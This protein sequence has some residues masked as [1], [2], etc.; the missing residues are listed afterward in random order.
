[1]HYAILGKRSATVAA[2]VPTRPDTPAP[3]GLSQ[4]PEAGSFLISPDLK[5]YL[6]ELEA[7]YGESIGEIPTTLL[8]STTSRI[9]LYRPHPSSPG[10]WENVLVSPGHGTFDPGFFNNDRYTKTQSNIF[11]AAVLIL[12]ASILLYTCIRVI[13][14]RNKRALVTLEIIGMPPSSIQH[15]LFRRLYSAALAAI[16]ASAFTLASLFVTD[17]SLPGTGFEIRSVDVERN[18][19]V[20][21]GCYLLG[22]LITLIMM[23]VGTWPRQPSQT[24]RPKENVRNRYDPYLAL[25]GLGATIGFSF[26]SLRLLRAAVKNGGEGNH[27]IWFWA[28]VAT[29]VVFAPFICRY[30]THVVS[31]TSI[32]IATLI[33]SPSLLI[34]SRHLVSDGAGSQVVRNGVLLI[35]LSVTAA[36][37]ALSTT[38]E[39]VRARDNIAALSDKI[40]RISYG[41]MQTK[42]INTRGEWQALPV[43]PYESISVYHNVSG[44]EQTAMLVA[45]TH[46]L[47]AWGLEADRTYSTAS[48]NDRMRLALGP[49]IQRF[50]TAKSLPA[51]QVEK[52]RRSDGEHVID[53]IYFDASGGSIDRLKVARVAAKSLSPFV[54]PKVGGEEWVAG[55][56]DESFQYRWLYVGT[57]A[58]TCLLLCAALIASE[59]NR[60]TL[61]AKVVPLARAFDL[62]TLPNKTVLVLNATI[63][64]ITLILGALITTPMAQIATAA[65]S[66]VG[67]IE[68]VIL[69]ILLMVG[70]VFVV[71]T[72][73]SLLTRANFKR[74]IATA[75]RGNDE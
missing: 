54:E 53:T 43:K 42:L 51:Q 1:M 22:L 6:P 65:N 30:V 19:Q 41:S 25:M 40:A 8:P 7:Q 12:P 37:F 44:I 10:E 33:K 34:S 46:A 3:L 2:I 47:S 24:N 58:V 48:L 69:K 18:W 59:E 49:G 14:N 56:N 21:I 23:L 4:W 73:L 64:G 35:V 17:L 32:K 28:S 70:A 9:V 38:A 57:G 66:A 67:G 26:Q 62:R 55:A 31:V 74:T 11:W 50:N 36:T 16:I 29:A 27:L 71:D 75:K 63:A 45:S 5:P 52:L 68:P 72:S 61:R 13:R 20:Y 15:L 60:K 39:S